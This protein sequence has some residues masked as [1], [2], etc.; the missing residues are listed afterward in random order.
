MVPDTGGCSDLRTSFSLACNCSMVAMKSFL[1]YPE[2]AWACSFSNW[3]VWRVTRNLN[4]NNT[5]RGRGAIWKIWHTFCLE[6]NVTSSLFYKYR[7]HGVYHEKDDHHVPAGGKKEVRD[8]IEH[9][10]AIMIHS[11]LDST[12]CKL[13]YC[14]RTTWYILHC[15]LLLTE[16]R[17]K[18]TMN[19]AVNCDRCILHNRDCVIVINWALLT[20]YLKQ[21]LIEYEMILLSVNC[22]W[23]SSNKVFNFNEIYNCILQSTVLCSKYYVSSMPRHHSSYIEYTI[24]PLEANNREA[25]KIKPI[26]RL[27]SNFSLSNFCP[28]EP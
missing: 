6:Y 5:F 21:K 8:N 14:E 2:P 19:S 4:L 3:K 27:R 26:L 13:N 18:W 15:K 1:L 10:T 25:I 12:F 24:A 20:I 22:T 11:E 17:T 16:F 7:P 23:W 28:N 9:F